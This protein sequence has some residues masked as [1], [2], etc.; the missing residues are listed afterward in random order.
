MWTSVD[1]NSN[2]FHT[3]K[4]KKLNRMASISE[5]VKIKNLTIVAH[6]IK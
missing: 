2:I 3:H 4:I 5:A 6:F 1:Y